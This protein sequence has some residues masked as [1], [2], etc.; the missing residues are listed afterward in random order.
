MN[1]SDLE[2]A[3]ESLIDWVIGSEPGEVTNYINKLRS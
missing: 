3:I 1:F 2:K